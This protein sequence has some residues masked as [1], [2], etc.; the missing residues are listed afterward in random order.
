MAYFG[1]WSENSD[2]RNFSVV[3]KASIRCRDGIFLNVPKIIHKTSQVQLLFF[4]P[5]MNFLVSFTVWLHFFGP[6]FKNKKKIKKSRKFSFWWGNIGCMRYHFKICLQNGRW[7]MW[8]ST[9]YSNHNT[10]YKFSNHLS[11]LYC[12][13]IWKF[14]N[15]LSAGINFWMKWHNN[16]KMNIFNV[17]VLNMN[18]NKWF[19]NFFLRT[20]LNRSSFSFSQ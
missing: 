3:A 4:C 1:I 16:A 18:E 17:A 19:A 20:I 2:L 6:N 5:K 9:L 13:K 11:F 15:N 7:K 14:I 10:T 12:L 8:S